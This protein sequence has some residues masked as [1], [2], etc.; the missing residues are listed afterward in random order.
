MVLALAGLGLLLLVWLIGAWKSGFFLIDR[1]TAVAGMGDSPG[2]EFSRR[3]QVVSL[4]RWSVA[5]L[6]EGKGDP[7]VLLH[8]CPFSSYEWRKII[9]V[10]V[11]SGHRIIAPDL[12]GLGDT[13]VHLNDD[14]RLPQD[15]EMVVALLDH[16]GIQQA[17]FVGHD[18][19]GATLQMLMRDDPER[20]RSAVLTNAEAYDQWPSKPERPYLGLAVNPITS[21]FFR[22]A[23]ASNRVRREAFAIA[24]L[25]PDRTMTDA[26]I[27]TY[28]RAH[29]A[30]PQRFARFRR[31]FR[32]QLDRENNLETMAALAGMRRFEK[33]TLILWG[34][35]DTNFGPPIAERLAKDIPGVVRLQWMVNSAHMPMEEEPDAYAAALFSFWKDVENKARPS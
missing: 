6:D 20:I 21:P 15:V 17:H 8:G 19:G 24:H 7:V 4:D 2:D 22:L 32:W 34:R 1:T 31:F 28:V 12:L 9:P 16:F 25:N 23:L 11:A 3:K 5:V 30:T 35:R 29:I 33:P 18:H 26:D 27:D 14:Y 10:L 13:L